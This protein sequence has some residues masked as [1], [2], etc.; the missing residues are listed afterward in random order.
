MSISAIPDNWISDTAISSEKVPLP[1]TIDVSDIVMIGSSIACISEQDTFAIHL[2]DAKNFSPLSKFAK[3]GEG[4]GE[5]LEP[6]IVVPLDSNLSIVDC[7]R[8]RVYDISMGDTL[9]LDTDLPN[10]IRETGKHQYGYII[11]N[12]REHLFKI[13]DFRTGEITD[14]LSM[15]TVSPELNDSEYFW[16]TN[17]KKA[18]FAFL[19]KRTVLIF[20]LKDG[21]LKNGNMLNSSLNEGEFAYSGVACLNDRFA[22]LSHTG[23]DFEKGTGNSGIEIYDYDGKPI[24]H[25][26][27]D[28]ITK[29]FVYDTENKRFVLT[30]IDDEFLNIIPYNP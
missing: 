2:L 8:S 19:K 27:T 29:R 23:V 18:V 10:Q 21:V 26:E 7:W 13:M 6:E 17:G 3:R 22:L 25:I 24:Q 20:D 4:P 1:I 28:L 11:L 9:Y 30:G 14:T 5:Y 16:A 12:G 15:S